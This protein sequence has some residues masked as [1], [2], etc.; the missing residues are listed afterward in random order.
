M[1]RRRS[2][3]SFTPMSNFDGTTWAGGPKLPDP[4]T[5][6]VSLLAGGGHPGRDQQHAAIRRWT[7]PRDCTVSIK[8]TIEH[9]GKDGDGVRA[10]IVTPHDGIVAQWTVTRRTASTDVSGIF[11]KQGEAIDFVVDAGPAN[12]D[13]F[14]SFSWKTVITKQSTPDAVAGDDT[15]TSWDSAAEFAGPT[16]HP[17][18]L[19]AWEKYAQVLLESN[20][21]A[22][23]D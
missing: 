10:R 15:G 22:F 3:K 17:E 19:T 11:V 21:F 6:Y 8:G 13:N 14:D 16:K 20:E 1:K 9:N 7:A 5:A 12:N 18:P 23:V 4:A 2:V